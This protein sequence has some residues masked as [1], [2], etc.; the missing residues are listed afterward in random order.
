MRA[1]G[2]LVLAAADAARVPGGTALAVDREAFAALVTERIAMHPQIRV[3]R[4]EV[5]SLPSPGIVATGPLTSDALAAVLRQRLGS[6]SLAFYDAIAPVVDIDS[7]DR[8]RVFRASRYGK[9]TMNCGSGVSCQGSGELRRPTADDGST[10]PEL[11]SAAVGDVEQGEGAYINC[12]LTREEYDAFIDA[13][14]AGDQHQAPRVRCR[15]L[16]RGVSAGRG[17][18]AAGPRCVAFWSAQ[19]CGARRS[20]DRPETVCRRPVTARGSGR[21]H[22]ESRRVSNAA[23]HRRPAAR[24][25]ND[26]G[27][28]G[29]GVPA[30]RIDPSQFL[31]ERTGGSDRRTSRCETTRTC[32][33]P[34]R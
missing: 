14:S 33:S 12:P 22:V 20:P 3:E 34:A 25:P 26:P 18:G 6:E 5:A 8:E 28:A 9:E 21:P 23:A 10:A 13:L 2:S 27:V 19:A 31:R 11:D 7:L 17:D 29:S 15:A 30:L 24:I 1:L 16:L 4:R 32:C